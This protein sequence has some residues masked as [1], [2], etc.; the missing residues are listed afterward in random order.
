MAN[1][2]KTAMLESMSEFIPL[3]KEIGMTERENFFETLLKMSDYGATYFAVRIIDSQGKSSL[4]SNNYRWLNIKQDEE[5][6]SDFSQHVQLE[7]GKV[8]YDQISLVSRCGDKLETSFLKKL[9]N[10]G[11]NNSVLNYQFFPNSRS[12][13]I[14]Y[15]MSDPENTDARDLIINNLSKLEKL[16]NKIQLLL[17][18]MMQSKQFN[19][20]KMQLVDKNL[21]AALWQKNNK[22]M[23]ANREENLLFLTKKER[24][25]LSL[26]KKGFSN[27]YIAHHLG[28][29]SFTARNHNTNIRA[30][31]GCSATKLLNFSH[32]KINSIR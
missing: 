20:Q 29:S 27:E 8:M 5:F 7:L 22:F 11:V 16:Q 3:I 15:F 1:F 21:I 30:K 2:K 10:Y 19:D 9:Q 26:F 12:V 17:D 25:Y 13:K 31:M 23:F 6:I 14:T 32:N 4:I 28:I 24:E 18:Y